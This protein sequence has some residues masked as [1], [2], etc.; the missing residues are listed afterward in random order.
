MILPCVSEIHLFVR[1]FNILAV[2]NSL[3]NL[4]FR[5]LKIQKPTVVAFNY[6]LCTLVHRPPELIIVK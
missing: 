5:I 2:L 6:Q 4:S 1:F 3:E